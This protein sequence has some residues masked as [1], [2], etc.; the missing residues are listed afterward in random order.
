MRKTINITVA[1]VEE[2]NNILYN[3]KNSSVIENNTDLCTLLTPGKYELLDDTFSISNA[4]SSISGIY[5]LEVSKFNTT[6]ETKYSLLQK[7]TTSNGDIATR[8]VSVN[9]ESTVFSSWKVNGELILSGVLTSGSTSIT[10]TD[11]DIKSTSTIS[12]YT[13]VFG[14]N[15]KTVTTEDGNITL[16]FTS[17]STDVNIKVSVK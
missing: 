14:V 11:P 3:N 2:I 13:D 7:I 1:K 15:P 5:K 16:T 9:G 4:P 12:V 8:R 6:S 17:Q 10:L